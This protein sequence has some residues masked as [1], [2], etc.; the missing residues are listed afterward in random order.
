MGASD[1]KSRADR[2]EFLLKCGRFAVVTPPVVSLMLTVGDKARA[3]DL[4]T[5]AVKKTTKTTTHKTTT[6]KTTSTKTI[7]TRTTTTT[8]TTATTPTTIT[9]TITVST[10]TLGMLLRPSDPTFM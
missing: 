9:T 5:S 3:D 8:A 4:Q 2:R 1:E 10:D 6:H 7:T